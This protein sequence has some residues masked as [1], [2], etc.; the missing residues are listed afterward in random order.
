MP[1]TE[2]PREIGERLM[3]ELTDAANWSGSAHQQRELAN[4]MAHTLRRSHRTLQQSTIRILANMLK[5]YDELN[6]D[7]DDPEKRVSDLRNEQAVDFAKTVA[8]IN[9]FFPYV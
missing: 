7:P 5:K 1:K 4:A 8:E 3:T 9:T 6:T 2:T